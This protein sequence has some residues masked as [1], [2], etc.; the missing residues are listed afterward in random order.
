MARIQ[1]RNT[2]NNSQAN[3]SFLEPSYPVT[4]GPVGINITEAQEKDLK[5]IYMKMT[6]VL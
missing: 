1:H 4:A 3:V 5:T 2:I 6:E